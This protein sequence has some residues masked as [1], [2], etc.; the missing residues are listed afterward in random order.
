MTAT[1]T[2]ELVLRDTVVDAGDGTLYTDDGGIY[3]YHAVI[4]SLDL[5][6]HE[7]R[8]PVVR[9]A[10]SLRAAWHPCAGVHVAYIAGCPVHRR[11][12]LDQLRPLHPCS[13]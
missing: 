6:P 5:Y 12:D 7:S 10:V 8:R 3:R 11:T 1:P 13:A 2:P 9:S 4:T